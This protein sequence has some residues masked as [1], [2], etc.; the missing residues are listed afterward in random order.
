MVLLGNFQVPASKLILLGEMASFEVKREG[1]IIC[2]EGEYGQ[3]I[4]IVLDGKAKVITTDNNKWDEGGKYHTTELARLGPGDYFGELVSAP[5]YLTISS[6][7][8]YI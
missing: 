6:I 8:Q 2:E 5:L 4:F 1:Q 7:H 3:D